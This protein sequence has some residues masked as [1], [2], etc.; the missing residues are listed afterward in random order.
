MCIFI[1]WGFSIRRTYL[2]ILVS[3]Q[4]P[5]VSTQDQS[6]HFKF[7]VSFDPDLFRHPNF[8]VDLPEL[9]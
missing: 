7:L 3:I 9:K 8:F 4:E 5:F 6:L 1:R 2:Q